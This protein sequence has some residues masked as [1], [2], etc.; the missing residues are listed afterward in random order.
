M[1]EKIENQ[2]NE[3]IKHLKVANRAGIEKERGTHILLKAKQEIIDHIE[4]KDEQVYEKLLKSITDKKT[5]SLVARH[6]NEMKT[7]LKQTLFFFDTHMEEYQEA[8]NGV[9]SKGAYP[10][11]STLSSF[12]DDF[13]RLLKLIA[14]RIGNEKEFIFPL[15]KKEAL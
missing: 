6:K 7:L 2:S 4:F 13:D 1:V 11:S 15:I 3:F 10:K 14:D 8:R 5:N 12:Q 9:L